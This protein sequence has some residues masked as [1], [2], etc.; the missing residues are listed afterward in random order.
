MRIFIIFIILVSVTACQDIYGASEQV[1]ACEK[2]ALSKLK[3]P[4]SYNPQQVTESLNEQGEH[5]TEISF[6]AW[7]DYKVPIPFN[8]ICTSDADLSQ[9]NLI[10]FKAIFWNKR[11]IR[12]AELDYIN[13]SLRTGHW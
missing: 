4:D 2:A 8:L 7:N 12:M 10:Q 13:Q 11:P 3:H 1:K 9:N 5:V 6:K